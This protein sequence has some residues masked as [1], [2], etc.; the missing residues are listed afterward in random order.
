M[1]VHP[2]LRVNLCFIGLAAAAAAA[3]AHATWHGP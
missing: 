1:V 3:A 2:S